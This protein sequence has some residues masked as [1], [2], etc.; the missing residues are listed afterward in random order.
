MG[1]KSYPE[2]EIK[3]TS[4]FLE[5]QESCFPAT[6]IKRENSFYL[7]L[8]LEIIRFWELEPG[9]TVLTELVKEKRIKEKG[10]DVW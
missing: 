6:I 8:D 1:D 9:D 7:R 5:D 4:I 10:G 2:V 3:P